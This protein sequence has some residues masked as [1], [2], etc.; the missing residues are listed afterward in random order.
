[1]EGGTVANLNGNVDEIDNIDFDID[2]DVNE[3]GRSIALGKYD[4]INDSQFDSINFGQKGTIRVDNEMSL[5]NFTPSTLSES[6]SKTMESKSTSRS[7]FEVQPSL[8]LSGQLEPQRSAPRAIPASLK[9]S[10][11][12]PQTSGSR[13]SSAGSTGTAFLNN[14]LNPASTFNSTQLSHTPPTH[15]S[16]SYEVS[17]FGKRPRSGVS[18]SALFTSLAPLFEIF[19]L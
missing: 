17:H 2:F 13:S 4:S 1:M 7:E 5:G 3:A 9:Q 12:Y 16:T 14:I 15:V 8:S 11:D 6:G 18:F 10:I 19:S